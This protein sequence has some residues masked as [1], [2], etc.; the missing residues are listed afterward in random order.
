[1]FIF[2]FHPFFQ[3][4]N[5]H[6]VM[7]IIFPIL[8]LI[9]WKSKSEECEKEFQEWKKQASAATTTISKLNRQINSKVREGFFLTP[10]FP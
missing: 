10:K 1:M 3:A 9:E 8:T 5:F 2:I 4:E 7:L 6:F